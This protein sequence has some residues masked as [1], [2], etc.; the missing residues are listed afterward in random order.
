MWSGIFTGMALANI[1]E[2]LPYND[3]L[4]HRLPEFIGAYVCGAIDKLPYQYQF[5]MK[6][7]GII[8]ALLCLLTTGHTLET[9]TPHTRHRAMRIFRFIPLERFLEKYVRAMAMLAYFDSPTNTTLSN[10]KQPIR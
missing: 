5:P 3:K 4:D 9:L 2:L 7:M 1:E 8:L 6:S 10:K